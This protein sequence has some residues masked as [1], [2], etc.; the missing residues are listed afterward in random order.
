MFDIRKKPTINIE[1]SNLE[2]YRISELKNKVLLINIYNVISLTTIKNVFRF[3][4]NYSKTNG[5]RT[6]IILD[7]SNITSIAGDDLVSFKNEY[8]AKQYSKDHN[9]KRI[10]RFSQIKM[11]LIQLLNGSI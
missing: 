1:R 11:Q 9:G 7:S 4:E 10:F 3:V 8:D 2:N 5:D 6:D